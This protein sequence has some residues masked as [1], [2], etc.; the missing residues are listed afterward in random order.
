MS[1]VTDQ[2][3]VA[4]LT[5][6]LVARASITPEDA[7]CQQFI[8]DYLDKLGFRCRFL[9]FADVSNLYC[10]LG[11]SGP[12]TIWLGHTDVVPPGPLDEWVS[13]PFEPTIRDSQLFGRGVADMKGA[14]AAMLVA[15]ENLKVDP[16]AMNGRLGVLLTSDE[17]G[18]AEH[19]VRRVVQTFA[20]ENIQPDF[21]LVGEPSSL[22]HLGDNVRVGR[23]GSLNG[24]LTVKGVQ[25][26][27]AYPELARNPIHEWAPV[28]CR[29]LEEVWDEGNA[30]FPAT[31]LQFSNVAAGTGAH[32]IIPGE[33]ALKFNFRY[34]SAVTDVQLE[35]RFT[36]MLEE[37]GLEFDLRWQ[38]SG[39]PFFTPEGDFTRTVVSA[40]RAETGREPALDTGGGT[41]DGR[42]IAPLGCDV[43]EFGLVNQ[44]IHK[45]NEH[46]P[47]EDLEQL[48]AIYKRI[49]QQLLT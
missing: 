6:A 49:F 47:L 11:T 4:K 40:I 26:H 12:L 9:P 41:S 16:T 19:G 25:G 18:P 13:P 48:A 34:S 33:L 44:S 20:E 29:L 46:A 37:A 36:T 45:L 22:N 30:Y 23:R 14:V 28:L 10:E 5:S 43:V 2:G 31:S 39:A 3:P 42:F 27:A 24:W 1:S 17:E 8:A 15:L 32:N 21:C 7:G 38:R 35:N